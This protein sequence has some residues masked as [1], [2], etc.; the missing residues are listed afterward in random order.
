M[1]TSLVSKNSKYTAIM[2]SDG[3]NFVIYKNYVAPSDGAS[4]TNLLCGILIL[5][6]IVELISIYAKWR[7]EYACPFFN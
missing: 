5:P 3:G 1:N 4:Y 7:F 2:Q 6:E